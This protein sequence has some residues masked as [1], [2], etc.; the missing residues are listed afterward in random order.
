MIKPSSFSND[1]FGH[2]LNQLGHGLIGAGIMAFLPLS[3]WSLIVVVAGYFILIECPQI[4]SNN[5]RRVRLD[6]IEDALHVCM[7][8]LF[9]LT[10][11]D[12]SVAAWLVVL[13]VG[14]WKRT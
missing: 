12:W 13:G 6:S 1:P 9:V 7:G 14:A 4:R 8:A 2:V 3:W 5:T 10:G 11:A